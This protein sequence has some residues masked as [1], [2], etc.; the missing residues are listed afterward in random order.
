MYTSLTRTPLTNPLLHLSNQSPQ[1]WYMWEGKNSLLV[2]WASW[3]RDILP[4][5]TAWQPNLR[6]RKSAL[7]SMVY[8]PNSHSKPYALLILA[9][10][11]DKCNDFVP[12]CITARHTTC[13]A[14]TLCKIPCK[15]RRY[16]VLHKCTHI[17]YH[18]IKD[19]LKMCQES[20]GAPIPFLLVPFGFHTRI[21]GNF[22]PFPK[23]EGQ[24]MG[25]GPKK[26]FVFQWSHTQIH[27]NQL[28]RMKKKMWWRLRCTQIG[29][30][31]HFFHIYLEELAYD[32]VGH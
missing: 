27:T 28:K 8:P 4:S 7:P 3:T 29:A 17:H 22:L 24:G 18:F 14:I 31:Y 2:W 23:G 12:S 5:C 16:L 32:C 1:G 26:L 19:S 21:T 13:T 9:M 15:G 11:V 10:A 20:K 30:T 6:E 25:D